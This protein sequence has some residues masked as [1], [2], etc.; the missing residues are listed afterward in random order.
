MFFILPNAIFLDNKEMMLVRAKVPLPLRHVI[1]W[2]SPEIVGWILNMGVKPNDPCEDFGHR[3]LH[4]AVEKGDDRL[5]IARIL[6]DRGADVHAVDEHGYTPLQ[7]TLRL[8]RPIL[9]MMKLL[10]SKGAKVDSVASNSNI[11]PLLTAVTFNQPLSVVKFLVEHGANPIEERTLEDG[12]TVLHRA[13]VHQRS[14]LIDYFLHLGMDVNVKSKSGLNLVSRRVIKDCT[15]NFFMFL[16]SHNAV[17]DKAV[18]QSL[19]NCLPGIG[20]YAEWKIRVY[21]LYRVM[22]SNNIAF[23]Q[24]CQPLSLNLE[25]AK[26]LPMFEMIALHELLTNEVNLW[27]QI[28]LSWRW[29][30]DTSSSAKRNCSA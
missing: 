7:R 5:E 16:M 27:N 8:R 30:F 14:D 22:K 21:M 1:N 19:L 28:F 26:T 25:A 4:A 23:Y 17:V 12:E 13:S 11:T 9:Q 3:A 15:P 24:V 10:V 18:L 6:L 20:K 29:K 2:A